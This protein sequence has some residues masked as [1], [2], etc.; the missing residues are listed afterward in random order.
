[1]TKKKLFLSS[2][3]ATCSFLR[4][5]FSHTH[6]HTRDRL[7]LFSFYIVFVYIKKKGFLAPLVHTAKREEESRGEEC[8]C[9]H[10]ILVS[11]VADVHT[12]THIEREKMPGMAWL[13]LLP[14]SPADREAVECRDQFEQ[15]FILL[16]P[17]FSTLSIPSSPSETF[18]HFS[19]TKTSTVCVEGGRGGGGGV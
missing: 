3:D 19:S 15:I 9:A 18:H 17:S 12:H 5:T 14:S 16:P 4:S 6:T 7:L 10:L 8:V 1:V 2:M 11:Y 13:V